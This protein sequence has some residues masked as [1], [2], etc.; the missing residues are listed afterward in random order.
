MSDVADLERAVRQ[1]SASELR[2]FREWFIEFDAE[3]WDRQIERDVAAGRLDGHAE[4]ALA[5]H[6]R[7][8]TRRL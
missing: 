4:E 1:L 6:R 7:K 8:R 3:L 5:E 2:E